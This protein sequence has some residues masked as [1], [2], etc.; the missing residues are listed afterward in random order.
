MTRV[1]TAVVIGGGIA[2]PVAALALHKAGIEATIHEAYPTAAEGLGD[3]IRRRDDGLIARLGAS[4]LGVGA[5]AKICSHRFS[6]FGQHLRFSFRFAGAVSVMLALRR[7][8]LDEVWSRSLCR[9][10]GDAETQTKRA[11]R[12][13]RRLEAGCSPVWRKRGWPSSLIAQR[14]LTEPRGWLA[15]PAQ[16]G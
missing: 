5:F 12:N 10:G 15:G 8:G 2:G 16:L 1:R 6:T 14:G 3:K 9:C 11:L 4:S 7:S 13:F